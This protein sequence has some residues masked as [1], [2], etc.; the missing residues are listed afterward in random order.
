MKIH[1]TILIT[2]FLLCFG[3]NS[4]ASFIEISNG[5]IW[6]NSDTTTDPTDDYFWIKNM[7]VFVGYTYTQQNAII[8]TISF[9][10]TNLQF[11]ND[12]HMATSAEIDN[13]IR[14]NY[15]G[16]INHYA[17]IA[18]FF[19]PTISGTGFQKWDGRFDRADVNNFDRHAGYRVAKNVVNSTYSSVYDQSLL[20]SD[21]THGAWVVATPNPDYKAVPEPGT[22]VLFGMGLLGFAG[23]NRKKR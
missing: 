16:T 17:D 4:S 7:A 11:N 9:F 8:S 1:I 12:W 14:N 21:I 20:D 10:G 22:M 13:G 2:V 23:V 18:E 5:V 6:N 3:G 19:T 15:S